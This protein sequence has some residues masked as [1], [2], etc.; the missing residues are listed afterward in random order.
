MT[1]SEDLNE[2]ASEWVH[3]PKL[4]SKKAKADKSRCRKQERQRKRM[5]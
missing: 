2:N 3:L 1:R 4:K 5:Y